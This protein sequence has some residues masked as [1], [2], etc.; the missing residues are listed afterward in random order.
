MGFFSFACARAQHD[1]ISAPADVRYFLGGS[2][3]YGFIWTHHADMGLLVKKHIVAGEIDLFKT[4]A[5]NKAWHDPYHYPTCGLAL[6]IIPLGNPDQTGTAIGLYPFVNFP[7]GK[8]ERR[9]K[10]SMRYGWGLGWL[11]KKFEPLDNHKNIVIGSHLNT[12]FSLRLNGMWCIDE[13]DRMEFGI[14]LTHFSNGAVTKPNL[15]FNIPL[16]S[17]GYFHSICIQK[18]YCRNHNMEND[19]ED[20]GVPAI[21][22]ILADHS[23]HLNT[24]LILGMNDVDPPGGNRYGVSALQACMIKQTGRKTRFGFGFDLMYSQAIQKR[25]GDEGISVNAAG[26]LQPGVKGVYELVLGRI[27][28][29][30]EIGTYIYSRYKGNGPIYS[31][32]GVRYL[33]TDHLV[34]NFSLKTHFAVAEYWEFGA[35]WRF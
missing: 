23:W 10:L 19:V 28:C 14:G 34:I 35:G 5:G 18:D 26:A 12:C 9:L 2:F 31:R 11:T 7:L 25:L 32:F 29:P 4:T 30:F 24:L 21:K 6:H 1:T 8:R 22:K 27:S 13:N 3:H 33:V 16:L 15:G 20:M 17:I